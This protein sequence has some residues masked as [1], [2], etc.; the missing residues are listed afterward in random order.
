M[1]DKVVHKMYLCK[2][3]SVEFCLMILFL[4]FGPFL[5]KFQSQMLLAFSNSKPW[6]PPKFIAN[7]TLK[8]MSRTDFVR[9]RSVMSENEPA[10]FAS[11]SFLI[12]VAGGQ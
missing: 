6:R 11:N 12:G 7:L 9:I 3:F 5:A 4:T 8:N 10:E 2:L 1:T